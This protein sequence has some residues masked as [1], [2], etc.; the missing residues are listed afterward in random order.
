MKKVTLILVAILFAVTGILAQVPNQFKYQAVLR[1]ADGTIIAEESVIIDISI[2]E[3]DLVTSVFDE[4]HTVTTTAQG[5]INLNIGSVEDL[6]VI[7]WTA[8]DY[9]IEITVN[10]T[11]MGT[12]Q[13]LSVPYALLSETARTSAD[14]TADV[15]TL[16]SAVDST[17][18]IK[19]GKIGIGT[20]D[21]EGELELKNGQIRINN[22][23]YS[24]IEYY[25]NGLDNWTTG[26]RT[27]D[28]YYIWR[29]V[30][31]SG[32]VLIPTG[33]TGIG[34]V[35]PNTK[36]EVTGEIT[37]NS[38]NSFRQVHGDY[39]VIHRIDNNAYYL[40]STNAE[41]QY[42]MWN[43]FRPL[44]YNIINGNI[45]LG[46]AVYANNSNHFVGI[47]LGNNNPAY[48]LDV[49]GNVNTTGSYLTNGSDFAEYFINEEELISGDIAGI[50]LETGKV[51]K[52]QIGDELVGIV[53][54]DAGYVGNNALDREND[55]DY[56]LVGLSGQ[57]EFDES[58]VIIENRVVKTIDGVKIGVLLANGKIFIR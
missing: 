47:G 17:L 38:Q 36:L 48:P 49:V 45:S 58:Q 31:S 37:A 7:D 41:D 6:S 14:W 34:T 43:D 16:Y 56:T 32:N 57:L 22:S 40:L 3:S 46:Q 29:G 27:D 18:V 50:N 52:Y 26:T 35:T 20:T 4:T 21:P 28:D 10:G 33:N 19:N 8:D 55:F 39:G 13:L 51:R 25:I 15:D 5:L 30:G 42:G 11:I 44:V 24:R 12:S 1:N 2:L 54:N 9:F 23:S 53:S